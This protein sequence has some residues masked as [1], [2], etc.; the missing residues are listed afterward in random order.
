[1]KSEGIILIGMS[2]VGKSTVGLA[3]AK[4]LEFDFIDGDKY[5]FEKDGKTIQEIIDDE[6]DEALL[7]LEKKRIYEIDL[8]RK[9]LAP[10]GSIVYHPDLMKY[11]KQN[12]VLV[13]LKDSLK[14]IETKL[15]GEWDRGIVGLKNKSLRQIYDEREPLY[16]KYADIA[17]SCH[18][19][20][21][22]RIAKEILDHFPGS[23][24]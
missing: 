16:S 23:A 18:G 5:I 11:L 15:T 22:D 3:L 20:S 24:K 9:V 7:Q 19:K 21:P 14:N 13:Y 1:M 12:A 10:G 4:A 8:S 6:G 2:G 17:V